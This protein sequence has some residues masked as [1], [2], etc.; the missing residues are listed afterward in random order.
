VEV[1]TLQARGFI[2]GFIPQLPQA[3][4]THLKAS[5][6]PVASTMVAEDKIRFGQILDLPSIY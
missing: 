1:L 5:V 4:H 2:T 6:L 3:D